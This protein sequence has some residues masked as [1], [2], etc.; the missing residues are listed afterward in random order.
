MAH[1]Y[2]S[3]LGTNDY[4]EC[5]YYRD[6]FQ[7][8][9]PVRFV[10]EATIRD[11][12][13]DWG[14]ADRI[15]IFTTKDAY[16]KNWCDDGHF[17]PKT[18]ER[19]KRKGLKSCL[20]ELKITVPFSQRWIPEGNEEQEI[21]EIFDKVSGSLEEGDEVVFDITHAF[22]SIPL[23]AIVVLNYVKVLK[24]VKLKGIF[25]GAFEALGPIHHVRTMPV[26][27]RQV[28]ILDLT[29]LDRLMDWTIA[30]DRFLA[31]GDAG[32]A[33]SLARSGVMSLLRESRGRDLAAR[34]IREMGDAMEDFSRMIFTCRGPE[35]EAT[36]GK[37]K[38][39]LRAAREL[40]LPRPF[41]PLFQR[42]E[43]RLNPFGSDSLRDGLAA[44]RWCVDHNLIQQGYTILEEVIFSH[45]VVEAGGDPLAHSHREI[46]SEA[47]VVV[48]M[49]WIEDRSRWG[50]Y[51]LKDPDMAMKMIDFIRNCGEL[52]RAVGGLRARRNDINHAG[53]TQGRLTVAK[54]N[55]FVSDLR[56]YMGQVERALFSKCGDSP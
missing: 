26:K 49:G 35:I 18:D 6:G 37:L 1:V 42:L 2:L 41:L 45:V 52:H 55:E 25:Y 34:S 38:A 17:D 56:D 13:M 10:Q 11:N 7:M 24:R 20:S 9:R 3:F 21:W 53:F 54:A 22:R 28:R 19:L 27:D 33:G 30:T 12:C 15:I 4:V 14:Q 51:A 29:S 40:D 44:A 23:L 50:K 16:D 31:T 39:K 32:M 5:Y 8:D 46:A 36:A 48:S 47:F 43:Q